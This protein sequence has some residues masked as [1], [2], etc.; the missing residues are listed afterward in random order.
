MIYGDR[1]VTPEPIFVDSWGWV[2]LFNDQ[3]PHYHVAARA[4]GGL[5]RKGHRFFL[6]NA[7]LYEA[8]RTT[9]RYYGNRALA[10]FG[11][12][13]FGTI[14][15]GRAVLLRCDDRLETTAWEL[16]LRFPDQDI[17]FTDCLSFAA[18]Q[19]EG[20]RTAFTGDIHFTLLGFNVIP[21]IG[22]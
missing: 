19:R 22:R 17:S 21:D 14:E 20:I 12:K 10:E 7:V 2:A 8:L 4:Y 3:D 9:Q 5:R 15:T 1:A 11:Y 16:Q 13:L 18:M 6:T